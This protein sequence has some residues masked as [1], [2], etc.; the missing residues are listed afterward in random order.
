MKR[1]GPAGPVWAV[2]KEAGGQGAE[3]KY[4]SRAHSR[5]DAKPPRRP[6]CP[7]LLRRDIELFAG[8]YAL[9][10]RGQIRW[11][12]APVRTAFSPV[13]RTRGQQCPASQLAQ[14]GVPASGAGRLTAA[15][16][17]PFGPIVQIMGLNKRLDATCNQRYDSLHSQGG[18]CGT[19]DSTSYGCSN[20]GSVA[21]EHG[22]CTT[23][24]FCRQEKGSGTVP[25]RRHSGIRGP[26]WWSPDRSN[27]KTP[28]A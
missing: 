21:R 10:D 25:R 13:R 23:G 9:S 20:D 6:G 12:S 16:G 7:S 15:R 8:E 3:D 19:Q 4:G 27:Q 26:R 22:Q 2:G 24:L 14:V 17:G 11:C 1:L 28:E 18:G 5:R